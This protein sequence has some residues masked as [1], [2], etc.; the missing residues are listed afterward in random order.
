MADPRGLML[1][2]SAPSGTGKTTLAR[3]LV[4][5]TPDAIFSVSVTTRQPRGH[6]RH[7]VDYSF[8]DHERF[9]AMRAEGELLEWAVVHGNCYGTPRRFADEATQGGKLVL[10]DIDVEGGAQI[11][12]R[13]PEA[14][15]VLLLPPSMDELER[16]LRSRGTDEEAVVQRRLEAARHEVARALR[17]YDYVL[18]NDQLDRAYGR[19]E[20]L[21]RS[22]RGIGSEADHACAEEL[23]NLQR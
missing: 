7:G 20:S 10:F 22:L 11:K 1:V 19:L 3:R 21:V 14:A 4:A 6:E 17:I 15:T 5:S 9:E 13:H 12:R 2:L 16:R 18:V 8:V 23:R